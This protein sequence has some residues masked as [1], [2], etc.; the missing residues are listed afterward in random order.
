MLKKKLTEAPVMSPPDWNKDWH[1]YID[2]S[3]FCLGIVLSQLDDEGKDHPVY[4]A[5]RQLSD[6]EINYGV[7]EKECLGIVVACKKFRYYLLGYKTFFH[8]DHSA[9]AQLVNKPDLS[10]RI[11]RWILLIQEFDHE[12][13]VRKGKAHTNADFLSRLRGVKQEESVEDSFPDEQLFHIEGEETQ[14]G[15]IIRFLLQLEIPPDLTHE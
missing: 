11:A 4:F 12:V 5:S 1:V 8:T 14:Y 10:G 7:T 13:I 2:A 15:E 9:L 6:A 3:N